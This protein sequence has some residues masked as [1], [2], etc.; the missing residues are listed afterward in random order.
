[1]LFQGEEWGA[2]SPFLYFTDH[3]DVELGR[4]V[5]TGRRKEFAAFGWN[6]DEIPDPQ[7]PETFERSKL[8]WNEREHEPHAGLL[9]WHRQLIELRRELAALSVGRLEDVR[10]Q[11]D[12]SAKWLVMERGNVAVACNLNQLT[13]VVPTTLSSNGKI[14]LA[15]EKRT[16]IFDGELILPRDS[17]AIM[18][19]Q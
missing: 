3:R 10:V 8:N 4:A 12:E 14:L 7:S 17:V 5:T 1:M 19:S 9:Q 16:Q 15:S 13:Q 18:L 11:F 2:N 6:P